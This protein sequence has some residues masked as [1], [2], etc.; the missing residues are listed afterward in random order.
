MTHLQAHHI[1]SYIQEKYGSG[2]LNLFRYLCSFPGA[3]DLLHTSNVPVLGVLRLKNPDKT[4]PVAL[5]EALATVSSVRILQNSENGRPSFKV[6]HLRR[7]E[8][9]SG[10]TIPDDKFHT[11]MLAEL[12]RR[13][14][15]D[16][17]IWE[18]PCAAITI[19]RD[20]FNVGF[21]L[22]DLDYTAVEKCILQPLRAT[23][24]ELDGVAKC[25]NDN[26]PLVS[27]P[28]QM[29]LY[30]NVQRLFVRLRMDNDL[31]SEVLAHNARN[32]PMGFVAEE[33]ATVTLEQSLAGKRGCV[34][35]AVVHD[36]IRSDVA[37]ILMGLHIDSTLEGTELKML[38]IWDPFSL[39]EIADAVQPVVSGGEQVEMFTDTVL[40]WFN[41]DPTA[42][43][44][45]VRI[46]GPGMCD[47]AGEAMYKPT[48]SV[49][50]AEN[51]CFVTGQEYGFDE[52]YNK[53]KAVHE[54][55][56]DMGSYADFNWALLL[57][58]RVLL[59]KSNWTL[60]PMAGTTF[61]RRK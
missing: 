17:A 44:N 27:V 15:G 4:M 18:R 61:I 32:P 38:T 23:H 19:G 56:V 5:R 28:A 60:L 40:L 36:T 50:D 29:A 20:A 45:T 25:I 51:A 1:A 47:M 55:K 7:G 39:I 33:C 54:T 2:Q 22:A 43:K 24:S 13:A 35:L 31:L 10:K 46:L 3:R 52:V 49:R 11:K 37:K 42:Q 34:D 16:Y 8:W 30:N 59:R 41:N 26:T 12:C 48:K 6:S 58:H 53:L 21:S 9:V 57:A 14:G